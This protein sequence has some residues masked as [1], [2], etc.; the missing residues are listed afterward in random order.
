MNNTDRYRTLAATQ[1]TSLDELPSIFELHREGRLRI[2]WA[3][4]D[5]INESAAIA[6]VGISPGWQQTQIA[7]EEAATALKEGK[8]YKTACIRAKMR[9]SFAGTMRNNLIEMPKASGSG[10]IEC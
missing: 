10:W 4:F 3:P 8:S 7:Y 5:Y 9:A 1:R 6:I 2:V